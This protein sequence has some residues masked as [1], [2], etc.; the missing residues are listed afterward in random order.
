MRNTPFAHMTVPIS[1]QTNRLRIL[2]IKCNLIGMLPKPYFLEN[3][4]GENETYSKIIN[5]FYTKH[6]PHTHDLRYF[7]P[8]DL[9]KIQEWYNTLPDFLREYKEQE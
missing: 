6:P 9:L 4:S 3:S 1:V 8:E 7:K 5:R 2:S